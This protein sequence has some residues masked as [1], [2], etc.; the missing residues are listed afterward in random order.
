MRSLVAA[1]ML[2]IP[3]YAA[4]AC[5][6]AEPNLPMEE[7]VAS[8]FASSDTVG[9]FEVVGRSSGT[10]QFGLKS[11][12]GR[13]VDLEPRH[14]FKGSQA[15]IVSPAG[16]LIFRSSCDIPYR[17]GSLVLVYA[18]AD[19]PA[20]LVGCAPSGPLVGRFEQL[21]VLFKL[22]QARH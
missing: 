13:W 1:F 4:H 11:E 19:R 8:L 22:S 20:S 16:P 12:R 15:P 3:P 2:L 17:K 6:C 18:S 7:H 14:L 10:R 21:P 5:S 9:V